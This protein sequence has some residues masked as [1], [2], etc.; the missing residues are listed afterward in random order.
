MGAPVTTRRNAIAWY[1]SASTPASP[2]PMWVSFHSQDPGDNGGSELAFIDGYSRV[3]QFAWSVISTTRGECDTSATSNLN[4]G[5]TTRTVRGF[6][7]WDSNAGG[8]FLFGDTVDN[9]P[10]AWLPLEA[11]DWAAGGVGIALSGSRAAGT[12]TTNLLRWWLNESPSRPA[13]TYLSLHHA[14]P[15]LT[16]ANEYNGG[17]YSRTNAISWDEVFGLPRVENGNTLTFGSAD[18]DW[19]GP[20][21][22]THMGIWDSSAGGTYIIGGPINGPP[23][24]KP[25][26]TQTIQILENQLAVTLL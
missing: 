18:P 5:V 20:G 21:P 10:I 19:G 8:N 6:G 16:G 24:A 26:P 4:S 1:F 14:D 12:L 17:G 13:N 2:S 7:V 15:G 25:N 3:G 22:I 9:S 11:I 23:L